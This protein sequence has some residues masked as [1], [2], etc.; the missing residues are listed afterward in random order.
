MTKPPLR[1]P[2]ATQVTR[3]YLGWWAWAL[4]LVVVALQTGCATTTPSTPPPGSPRPI[5]AL[6]PTPVIVLGEQHDAD[7]H[8]RWH[9]QVVDQLAQQQQ[10]AALVMEMAETGRDTR[11]LGPQASETD[12]QSALNWDSRGWPWLRYGPVV[13]AAVRAGVVVWG[14]NLPRPDLPST[15]SDT[16]IDNWLDAATM[17]H[18]RAAIEASHC[19]LLPAAQIP[20]MARVQLA[21]DRAMAQAVGRVWRPGQVVV[22]VTGNEH[23]RPDTGVPRHL[24]LLPPPWPQT[25][26][27]VRVVHMRTAPLDPER[28]SQASDPTAATTTW[29]S[30]PLPPQDHC[31][32]LRRVMPTSARSP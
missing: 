13:M 21:R 7:T 30:E 9:T 26:G 3:T 27:P 2:I 10:L 19:G 23:A 18:H 28:G 32:S 22:L 25:A 31:A 1:V 29:L 11:G 16:R 24:A 6:L 4:V 14:G 12:A 5:A 8:Q 15:L 20:R 17:A